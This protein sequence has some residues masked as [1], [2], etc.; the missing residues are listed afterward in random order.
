[1]FLSLG[2]LHV[3]KISDVK[4]S[5]ASFYC[6]GNTDFNPPYVEKFHQSV[7]NSVVQSH[8]LSAKLS[9][10]DEVSANPTWDDLHC[11]F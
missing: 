7:V 6:Y 4:I 10:D 11:T 2:G 5:T 9:F 3:E 1:M 8:V